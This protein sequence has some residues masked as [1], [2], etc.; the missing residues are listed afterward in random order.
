MSPQAFSLDAYFER[1]GF[2]GRAA[3]DAQ[4]LDAM[5][6][7]QLATIPF[8]NFD[9][10][11]GRGVAL[12]PAALVEKLVGR[13]RGG[14]CFE[15]NGLLLLALRAIG[16]DVRPLLARVHLRGNPT[17]R[18]HVLLLVE[19]GRRSWV[20]DAGFGGPSLRGPIPFEL[21]VV[22]EQQGESFRLVGAGELGTMLQ[23]QTSAGWKHLYSFDLDTALDAD[24]ALANRYTA[25]HPESRFTGTRIAAVHHPR[26]RTTL[27]DFRLRQLV[28]G[29]AREATLA[30]DASYLD[31]LTRHF[32]ID[33]GAPYAAL[34]PVRV[35]G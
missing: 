24:I 2:T 19:L 10:L 15:L 13:R 28:D 22:R 30:D 17:G 31:A 18:T 11:L 35:A 16:F 26:G 33:I 14:Y 21:D 9:I 25:T 1:V 4:T 34:P 8:E 12:A 7:A 27:E 3:A 6:R 5:Q 20:V 23:M 29:T 32:G